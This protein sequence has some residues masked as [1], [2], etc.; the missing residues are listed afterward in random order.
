[1][2]LCVD[3]ACWLLI[4]FIDLL[5]FIDW[6]VLTWLLV[7]DACGHLC[8]LL[9][10][11]LHTVFIIDRS[12]YVVLP[13]VIDT[14]ALHQM[15]ALVVALL[16][17]LYATL[18]A[19]VQPRQLWVGSPISAAQVLASA[20]GIDACYCT[21]L[22]SCILS[23]QANTSTS[24][25]CSCDSYDCGRNSTVRANEGVVLQVPCMSCV[26]HSCFSEMGIALLQVNASMSENSVQI[27]CQ[28]GNQI[29]DDSR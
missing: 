17:I 25:G 7:T 22:P 10:N 12:S 24:D 2:K 3:V 21:D 8:N 18:S 23:S 6:Q 14:S 20:T 15:A 5:A 19:A 9:Y 16:C 27:P 4:A 11:G 28:V 26:L 1:M 29:F 13:A